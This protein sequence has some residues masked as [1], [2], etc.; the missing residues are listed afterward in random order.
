MKNDDD[1]DDNSDDNDDDDD[2][3]QLVK[4]KSKCF[5][6]VPDEFGE[7]LGIH[8]HCLIVA[9]LFETPWMDGW[10]DKEMDE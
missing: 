6:K 3:D 9:L 1:D 2:D 10:M 8:F 7:P 4:V 5:G